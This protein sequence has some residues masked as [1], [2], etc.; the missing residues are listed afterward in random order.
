MA[1]ALD[2]A[3]ELRQEQVQLSRELRNA[4]QRLRRSSA[5]PH[6]AQQLEKGGAHDVCPRVKQKIAKNLL[7]LL[8]LAN[9][10]SDIV[11]SYALGQGRPE[12]CRDHGFDVSDP[13]TR[14]HISSGVELL[15]LG[16]SFSLVSGLLEAGD[17][18]VYD[19][20]KYVIEY[21]LFQWLV[22]QNC[23][24]GVYPRADQVFARACSFLPA[25]AP[26]HVQQQLKTFFLNGDRSARYWLCTFKQRWGVNLGMPPAGEDLQPGQ[27]DS[28]DPWP[29]LF[30]C[31]GV[32]FQFLGPSFWGQK[33]IPKLGPS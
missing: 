7:L 26:A 6:I 10:C 32:F 29:D 17:R 22:K 21:H 9:F 25:A 8:E 15:Y 24:K 18:H 20:C 27:L 5:E 3:A 23:E 11:V 31:Q 2:M 1:S 28:K 16:V 13:D 14:R 19:I 4:Q 30:A 33:L 12:G